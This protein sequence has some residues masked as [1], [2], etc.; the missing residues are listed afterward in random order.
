MDIGSMGDEAKKTTVAQHVFIE[1]QSC[2]INV[3]FS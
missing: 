1:D 3:W 2:E